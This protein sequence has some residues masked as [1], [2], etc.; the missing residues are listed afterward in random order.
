MNCGV[1][2]KH[3]LDRTLLWLWYRL[4]TTA[5]IPPLDWELPYDSPVAIKRPPQKKRE[6][7]RKAEDNKKIYMH[8]GN[9]TTVVPEKDDYLSV[10]IFFIEEIIQECSSKS[11]SN[12]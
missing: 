2:C 1:D 4:A 3:N 7:E 6:R 11:F 10:F 8:Q 9:V 5:L 12:D